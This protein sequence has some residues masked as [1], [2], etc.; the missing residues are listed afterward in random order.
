MF[1]CAGLLLGA[2]R[3]IV[4][5]LGDFSAGTRDAVGVGAHPL[6]HQRQAALN[7]VQGVEQSGN[8]IAPCR[9]GCH[10]QIAFG[11]GL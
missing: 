3:K 9:G 6:H 10:S 11:H 1:Y 4:V 2:H 5:A 7:V 8:F